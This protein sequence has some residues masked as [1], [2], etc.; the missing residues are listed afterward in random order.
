MLIWAVLCYANTFVEVLMGLVL[1][2]KPETMILDL[3]TEN[4]SG[5]ATLSDKKW[6]FALGSALC[7][8]GVSTFFA[9]DATSW[10]SQKAVCLCN[11]SFH[12]LVVAQKARAVVGGEK[13]DVP[14]TVIH[15]P[16]ALGFILFAFGQ[17]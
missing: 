11:A 7:A 13:L 16:L 14:P 2:A 5:P 12:S 3:K 15:L 9:R 4:R 8:I 17:I 10:K 6:G 1:S